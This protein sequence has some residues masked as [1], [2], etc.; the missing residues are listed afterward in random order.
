MSAEDLGFVPF[1]DLDTDRPV[2]VI[3]A[4]G[5]DIV[6]T[7]KDDL[8]PG[9]S[10][11]AHIRSS[12]GG[13]A[14]NVAENLARLG[15]PVTLLSIL[16]DDHEGRQMLEQTAR[17][18]VKVEKVLVSPVFPTS[19]Y[20]AVIDDDGKLRFALDDMRAMSLLTP[21]YL[22]ENSSLFKEASLLFVD[23]NVPKDTLRTV[24]AHAKK[25][26]LPVVADPTAVSLAH[27]FQRYLEQIYMITP[28]GAEAAV[29]CGCAI[30]TSNPRE[31]LSA[32][33]ILVSQGVKIAIVTMAEFGVCYAT[34]Q[35]SGYIPAVRTQ[36]T[37]PTGAGD[38]LTS[39]VI[40]ALL[41][42]IDLDEAVRLAV[43][44]AS[45]TLTHNGAVLPD[46]SLEKLYDHLV[47]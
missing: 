7:L 21:N 8:H 17:A 33:K 42:G 27:R 43:T 25:A 47:I 44:A 6:G 32:A 41:N 13:V 38:A 2:L 3:G 4:A 1:E 35:T 11:R 36:I 23:A 30:D 20:V 9:T 22:R 10:T 45:L 15:Q 28:N 19:S 12:F 40:F 39:A 14:R 31:S 34:S 26:G 16:G 24:M 5:I 18:G 37:D 46:L 29:Y